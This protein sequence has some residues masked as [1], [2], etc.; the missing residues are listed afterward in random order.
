[1]KAF[2]NKWI[3]LLSVSG[4]RDSRGSLDWTEVLGLLAPEVL[5]GCGATCWKPCSMALRKMSAT[6]SRN[7][8]L[9]H[10]YTSCTSVSSV[11][12]SRFWE[13]FTSTMAFC[14]AP[15]RSAIILG[16]E[17]GQGWVRTAEEK[18]LSF[19]LSLF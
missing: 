1:M 16:E 5:L 13:Y 14:S 11:V 7:S 4:G 12:P 9:A 10:R 6:V 3:L 17:G 15:G 18:C 8:M 2:V 19:F